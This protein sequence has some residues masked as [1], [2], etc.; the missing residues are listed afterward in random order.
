MCGKDRLKT[1]SY[2]NLKITPY[3]NLV[4]EYAEKNKLIQ[5]KYVLARIELMRRK[6]VGKMLK[7]YYNHDLSEN[8]SS[9]AFVV[10]QLCSTQRSFGD[11]ILLADY[12]N[13]K[14]TKIIHFDY[15]NNYFKKVDTM[16]QIP[17]KI[18]SNFRKIIDILITNSLKR[19]KLKDFDMFIKSV[20]GVTLYNSSNCYKY[21]VLVKDYLK[22]EHYSSHI[23]IVNI[24]DQPSW[25]N[26][27]KFTAGGTLYFAYDAFTHKYLKSYLGR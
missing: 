11:I 13:A 15:K 25:S 16:K 4:D 8:I 10:I 19:A 24:S 3:L 18:T 23:I 12:R 9:N 27:N 14:I 22:L 26:P 5:K 20:K 2:K 17:L 7:S 6:N 21:D 1:F